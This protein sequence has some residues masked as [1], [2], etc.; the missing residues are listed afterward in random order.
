MNDDL[1]LPRTHAWCGAIVH[2]ALVSGTKKVGRSVIGSWAGPATR[3]HRTTATRRSCSYPTSGQSWAGLPP[4]L[5]YQRVRELVIFVGVI[6]DRGRQANE[7]LRKHRPVLHGHFDLVLRPQILLQV[8]KEEIR[9][10]ARCV[11]PAKLL[12]SAARTTSSSL[13]V[14]SATARAR[15][16][17]SSA[18]PYLAL[19]RRTS[20]KSVITS[21]REDAHWGTHCWNTP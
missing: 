1:R 17:S 6:V 2:Q 7:A 8:I 5:L 10:R 3:E 19:L 12:R 21:Q 9:R 11:G 20:A 18:S 13:G 16:K 14:E 4:Y 15:R